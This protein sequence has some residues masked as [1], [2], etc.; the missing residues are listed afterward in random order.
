ML[1]SLFP[2]DLDLPQIEHSLQTAEACRAEFTEAGS[3]FMHLV[4]F[5]HGEGGLDWVGSKR[6]S[7]NVRGTDKSRLSPRCVPVDCSH[8]RPRRIAVSVSDPTER[9]TS[10]TRETLELWDVTF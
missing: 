8:S 10:T 5:I 4:G 6:A 3:D 9:A 2:T 1:A 7:S